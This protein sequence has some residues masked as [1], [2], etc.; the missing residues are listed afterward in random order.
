MKML[1]A[2]NSYTGNNS[3]LFT[4]LRAELISKSNKF[5]VRKIFETM[6]FL[7][8][9]V[10]IAEVSVFKFSVEQRKIILKFVFC[11]LLT[12]EKYIGLSY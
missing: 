12:I 3:Q 6:K 9:V 5:V 1:L 10:Y 8:S 2:E 11:E 4:H 7:Q